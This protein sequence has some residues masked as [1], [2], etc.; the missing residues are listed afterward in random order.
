MHAVALSIPQQAQRSGR[1]E[2]TIEAVLAEEVNLARF[3]AIKTLRRLFDTEGFTVED[4]EKVLDHAVMRPLLDQI[5]LSDV[6][7]RQARKPELVQ[8]LRMPEQVSLPMPAPV[9]KLPAKQD[10]ASVVREEITA[11]LR[12]NVPRCYSEQTLIAYLDSILDEQFRAALPHRVR[13]ILRMLQQEAII[14]LDE[15]RGGWRHD[16]VT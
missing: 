10:A 13:R 4:L 6:L 5:N 7:G 3:R 16:C 12:V 15:S 1:C 14:V 8:E 2:S 9:P 11:F